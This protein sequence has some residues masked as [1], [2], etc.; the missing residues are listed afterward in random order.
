GKK[1][2]GKGG[3]PFYNPFSGIKFNAPN[4][5][6]CSDPT[7]LACTAQVFAALAYL[8]YRATALDNFSLR[9]EYYDDM[10]GQRTSVKT[11]YV[12][13]A[14]GWQHWFSP[15]IELR[16]EIAYYAS[17]DAPAFNAHF[18]PLPPPIPPT[19]NY[20]LIGAMDLI[21]HF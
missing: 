17:L 5:A 3:T 8:N 12:D 14:L 15:Q 2:M 1:I 19:K 20:A 9:L 13:A 7:V 18:N 4:G 21:F 6:Q 10:Q 11:R 16:P